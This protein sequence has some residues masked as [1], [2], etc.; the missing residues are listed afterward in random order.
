MVGF[1]KN[2]WLVCKNITDNIEFLKSTEVRKALQTPMCRKCVA[3]WEIHNKYYH[4]ILYISPTERI[5]HINKTFDAFFAELC[6]GIHS[7]DLFDGE[8]KN[9]II[10]EIENI[11]NED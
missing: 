8:K 5:D 9:K 3:L 11:K 7:S 2:V 6:R 1:C 10:E 4:E